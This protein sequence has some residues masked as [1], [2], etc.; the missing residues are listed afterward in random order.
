MKFKQVTVEKKIHQLSQAYAF[1]M[2]EQCSGHQ[3][4]EV[5]DKKKPY[6]NDPRHWIYVRVV[7]GDSFFFS[8]VTSESMSSMKRLLFALVTR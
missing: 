2:V 5:T 6:H 3:A 8:S 1:V 7:E 4:V